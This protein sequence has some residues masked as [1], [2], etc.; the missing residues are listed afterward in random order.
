MSSLIMVGRIE[1]RRVDQLKAHPQNARTHSEAQVEQI[2]ASIREFGFVNP[3]LIATDNGIIAGHAR[4]RAARKL[5]MSEV[6]V[7]VLGHLTAKQRRALAIADNQLPLN[8]G[9]DEEVLRL[10]LA[11]LQQEE[12]DLKLIGF[13]DA[14]LARLLAEQDSGGELTDA[15]ALPHVKGADHRARGFVD[16]GKPSTTLRRCHQHGSD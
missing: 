8:A 3:I 16:S 13:D 10:E 11:T 12:F 7:I 9:W 14:E 1:Q 6:P 2:V 5:G 15:D 4:L